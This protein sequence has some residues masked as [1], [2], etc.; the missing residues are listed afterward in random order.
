MK[1]SR[2]SY[3]AAIAGLSMTVAIGCANQT[4]PT[5][6]AADS[7]ETGGEVN[8]YSSR[9]YDTDDQLY[10]MFTEQ[11]GIRVNVIE[12]RDD[13]M[14]ERIISEG[15]NSPADVLVTVDAGRLWR[16]QEAGILQPIDSPT[17]N[18]AIPEYLREPQGHWFGLT[19][20]ARVI[21]YNK[22]RVNPDQLSTY[23]A[24]AAPEWQGRICVR[25]SSHVYNQSLLGSM[26]E[27]DGE[28]RAEEWTKGIV[29][30][31]AREPEGGDTDQIK[32]VAAGQ[33][34]VA[35]SNHYY[36]A[37]LATSEDAADREIAEQIGVFFPNQG[38]RGTHVNISGAGV[39]A[40][41]PNR[42]NAIRFIEFLAST[43]AQQIF[44]EGNLEFPA[45]EGV[46]LA[47]VVAELGDFKADT[48]NVSTYGKNN[49]KAVQ[50]FDRS[51]WR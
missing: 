43:D 32:A 14:I 45:V 42:E 3:L 47:P 1:L 23:E 5:T 46:P 21:M 16:A 20:R 6:T 4:S 44:A 18:Q 31:L 37:R 22:D 29:A 10:T 33:C 35:I 36:W 8:V 2:R 38:D 17:L 13:E 39:T 9:H 48:V 11:T 50:I 51:N 30:N 40:N 15:V 7:A 12:G 25:S 19:R 26:I 34:D 41:A 27:T 28:A 24:L 49:P